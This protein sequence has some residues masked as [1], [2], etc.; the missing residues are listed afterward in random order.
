MT[1]ILAGAGAALWFGILTSISPCPLATNLTAISYM[2][3][4]INHPRRVLLSGLL[5]TLGRVVAYTALAA[6]L[7]ASAL[8][9]PAISMGLQRYGNLIL[10]PVLIVVGMFLLELLSLPTRGGGV[11][12]RLQQRADAAGIWGAALLGFVFALSFCP[13][14]AALFF[15]SLLPLALKVRSRFLLPALF[16][17]GTALPVIAASVVLTL[18]G[19]ATSRFF[20]KMTS[21]ELWVRRATGA[22]FVLVGIYYCLKYIFGLAI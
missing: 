8:S 19:K 17:I 21:L 7:V 2:A 1:G 3:R 20:E 14:S 6:L 4:T 22:V 15:G 5:Y 12:T 13:T 16:G 11:S 9:V 10:G 18:G